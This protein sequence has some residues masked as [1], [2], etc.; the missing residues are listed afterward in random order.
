MN[1]LMPKGFVQNSSFLKIKVNL[2]PSALVS[3]DLHMNQRIESGILSILFDY[4]P[5]TE[6]H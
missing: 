5:G 4:L 6:H 1:D 3:L 2:R